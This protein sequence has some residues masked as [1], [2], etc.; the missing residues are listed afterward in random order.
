MTNMTMTTTRSQILATM[1]P[2]F[3]IYSLCGQ[4]LW[5]YSYFVTTVLNALEHYKIKRTPYMSY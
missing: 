1:S 3:Q 5:S 4:P 2:K